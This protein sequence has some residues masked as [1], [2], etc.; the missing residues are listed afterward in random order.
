MDSAQRKRHALSIMMLDID[1]FKQV[2][3]T[4]GHQV[5]DEVLIETARLV[6]HCLRKSDYVIRY[7]GEEFLTCLPKTSLHPAADIA[8]QLRQTIAGHTFS[9]VSRITVSIGI[10]EYA[11]GESRE[12]YIRRADEQLYAAKQSGRN[13]DCFEEA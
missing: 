7:G 8:E 13:G 2:N 1:H 6:R 11:Y 9:S 12:S 10:A 5:G 3:D 4:Y